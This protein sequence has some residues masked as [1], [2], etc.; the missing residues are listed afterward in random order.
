MKPKSLLLLLALLLPGALP[1][2]AQTAADA[3]VA[4]GRRIYL[5]GV[6]PDGK[7][8]QG[9]RPDIG[10]VS[11]SAAACVSCHRGS[12]L[13]QVEGTTGIPPISGR[14]LFG[15]GEPVV[16]RMDRQFDRRVSVAHPPYSPEAFSAAVREGRHPD[17][18]AMNALMPHF[19]LT[20]GPL[21]A[22]AAYLQTLSPAMSAA[23]VGDT[24]HMATVIAPGVEP[25]RRQAFVNTLTTAVQQMNINVMTGRRQKMVALEERR[26][27]SRRKWAL[28]IWE[29]SG[30]SETWAEQLVQRQKQQPVFALVSGLSNG[31]WQP[32]QD[33]CEARRVAC[34]FPS[35]DQVPADAAQSQF[36]LYFSGGVALE[37]QVMARRLKADGGRIVQLVA[38][39]AVARSAAAALRQSLVAG[40]TD[41]TRLALQEVDAHADRA[42]V[43]AAIAGLG[44]QDTLVLWL[45]PADVAGLAALAQ[46]H[47]RVLVSASLGGDEQLALPASL[48]QNATLVQPLELPRLRTVNVERLQAWLAASQVPLV[49]LRLQSE[50][51]FAAGALQATLRGMLNNL[52]TDYLI[53]RAESTLGG[54]ETMQ[55]Q[56]EIQAMMMAPMNK[57]PLQTAQATLAQAAATEALAK[58]QMAHLEEMRLRGGTTVY[59]RLSLA[60]GQRFASKGAYLARLNPDAPGVTGEPEWVV[61]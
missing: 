52:H 45:R 41:G 49:D 57:R 37:A 50:V 33:F 22:L 8:L 28:D 3:E 61:P 30:P 23:V 35:V 40:S 16:V 15:G 42:T 38:P 59:P 51:F 31:E 21:R 6:L 55:V 25:A 11:G 39:D 26:L 48:R 46:T 17:G 9:M 60:Q 54:F 14:T 29:L 32:V 13:G 53:E 12:G 18:R 5:E 56:E 43:Q 27:Q 19:A 34:W 7:P 4:A 10:A 1:V 58:A 2:L 44:A 20:E 24:I 47:A 36:S